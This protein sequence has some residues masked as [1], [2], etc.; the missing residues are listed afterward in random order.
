VGSVKR[1]DSATATQTAKPLYYRNAR[2]RS[3]TR[4]ADRAGPNVDELPRLSFHDLR[5]A[6]FARR[7]RSGADVAQVRRFAGHS[8]ASTSL[9]IDV[10]HAGALG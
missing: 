4:A 3:L 10:G 1:R 6:A 9:D 7:I 5:H 8:K 2:G